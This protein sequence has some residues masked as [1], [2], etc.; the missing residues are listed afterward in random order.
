MQT[1][2]NKQRA[3]LKKV[4]H[5]EKPI[6]QLGKEGLTEAFI[7]QVDQ[8][9]EKRELIKFKIL[10]NSL[11]EIEEA[12]A[13]IAYAVEATVVQVIGH[14]GVLYRPSHTVKHQK[15]S[16]EVKKIK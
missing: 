1:L 9:L 7:T 14:S 6:F 16:N 3:Y 12:T 5:H 2:T 15:L 10:Q 4:A 8:A 13:E 11:E